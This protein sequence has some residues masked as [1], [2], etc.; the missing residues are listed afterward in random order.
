MLRLRSEQLEIY[1]HGHEKMD[2]QTVP[3][4]RL[5]LKPLRGLDR[6]FVQTY[7]RPRRTRTNR[8]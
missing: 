7:P 8:T 3:R 5:E 4:R 2:R 1:F 6:F